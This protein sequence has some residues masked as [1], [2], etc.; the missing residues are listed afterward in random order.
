MKVVVAVDSIFGNTRLVGEA[1]KEE[2][3]KARDY[4]R[5]LMT[6]AH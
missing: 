4:A 5:Q 2:F 1:L 3:E 6:S